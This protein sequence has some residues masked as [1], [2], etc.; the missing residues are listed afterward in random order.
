MKMRLSKVYSVLGA[1]NS[2]LSEPVLE[3]EAVEEEVAD[4]D[5]EFDRDMVDFERIVQDLV[6]SVE[7][8]NELGIRTALVELEVQAMLIAT[9]F[10]NLAKDTTE[11]MTARA[12]SL[13]DFED[14]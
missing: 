11:V 8:N 5:A 6:R 12:G 7:S 1:L 4:A 2:K 3:P 13:S 14:E 10:S 9:T